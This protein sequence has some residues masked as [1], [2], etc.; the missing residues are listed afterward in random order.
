MTKKV[1]PKL[2]NTKVPEVVFKT[3]DKLKEGEQCS[4]EDLYDLSTKEIFENKKIVLFA[5]PGAYTPTCSSQHLPGYEENYDKLKELGVDEV[6]V[7]S[8]NDAF[9]MVNWARDLNVQK[10]QIIP[11][12]N[13][14]FTEK[15]GMLVDKANLGFGKRSW[16]YS[17]YVENGEIKKV[18]SEKGFSDNFK[19]DPF[20]VSNAQTML[21]YLK[22]QK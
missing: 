3:A 16:R 1:Q 10:V 15:I 19:D 8:V 13:A 5:L 14:E 9:V 2:E 11:D 17:M 18:F 4:G 12:G 21:D 6:Y 7:L 20:E 22:T